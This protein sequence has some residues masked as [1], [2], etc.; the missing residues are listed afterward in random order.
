MKK[1]IL[2]IVQARTGSTRLPGKV[3]LDLGGRT[4]LERVVERVSAS[5][6]VDDIVV[7]TTV[8]PADLEIVK[9]CLSAGIKVYRGSECDVLDRYYQAAKMFSAGHILRVT[10]DCPL[11][12]PGII[13]DLIKLHL[14]QKNDYTANIIRETFPDG[15]DAE[16]LT[17]NTLESAWKSAKLPSEREHVTP[18][19]RKRPGIFKMSNLSCRHDLSGKRWTLDERKDYKFIK[20]VYEKLHKKNKIFGMQDV[21][22]LLK[23]HPD[24]ESINEN[25]RRNAGYLKSLK[26]DRVFS[27]GHTHE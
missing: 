21:L 14:K 15:E 26:H 2:A 9:L 16:I 13:S 24:Y 10:A 17:F 25:L 12:D 5:K 4:V 8:S 6:L 18:Y 3:L 1:R 19:I 23:K 27:G 22:D 20:L 7:A 11:I